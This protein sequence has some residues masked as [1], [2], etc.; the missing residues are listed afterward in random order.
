MAPCGNGCF[1]HVA[2]VHD[3]AAQGPESENTADL[4][5]CERR[6]AVGEKKRDAESQAIASSPLL[7]TMD[8]SFRDGPLGRFSP[9]SHSLISFGFTLR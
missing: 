5:L 3:E 8:K 2:S 1:W 6:L 7:F 4:S 9:R